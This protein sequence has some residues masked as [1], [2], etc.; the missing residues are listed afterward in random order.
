MAAFFG[1]R[2]EGL[3]SS[4]AARASEDHPGR[5]AETSR[6]PVVQA[7]SAARRS[8]TPTRGRER[9]SNAATL[10]FQRPS[11]LIGSCCRRCRQN[12]S[13]APASRRRHGQARP[14][15]TGRHV[16]EGND[17]FDEPRSAPA[18]HRSSR[19]IDPSS[20]VSCHA[21]I[22]TYSSFAFIRLATRRIWSMN[23]PPDLVRSPPCA[24]VAAGLTDA[25]GVG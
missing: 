6:D 7:C 17:Y 11:L 4:E 8:N 1:P 23:S 3:K 16:S 20:T 24:G 22:T 18:W 2:A 5:H 9:A 14:R 19:D 21:A 13:V 25:I 12:S 15:R 10:P